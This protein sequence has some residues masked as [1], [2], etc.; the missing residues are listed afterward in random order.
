[1]AIGQT[2]SSYS[3]ACI[4]IKLILGPLFQIH[5]D[6]DTQIAE[7]RRLRERFEPLR[8]MAE[9]EAGLVLYFSIEELAT[10]APLPADLAVV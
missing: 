7:L 6:P 8:K 2:D 3:R 9:S 4:K 10:E 5:H 1:V